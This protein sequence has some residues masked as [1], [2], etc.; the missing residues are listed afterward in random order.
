MSRNKRGVAKWLWIFIFLG[1]LISSCSGPSHR[2]IQ[3]SC[4]NQIETKVQISVLKKQIQ[5]EKDEKKLYSLLNRLEV[6]EREN[7]R[8][9]KLCGRHSEEQGMGQSILSSPNPRNDTEWLK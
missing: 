1:L 3:E 7:R 4:K 6:H 9:N 5:D 2:Q 8:L